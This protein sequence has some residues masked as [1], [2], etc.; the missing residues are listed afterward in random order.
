MLERTD[1]HF[2]FFFRLISHRARLYTE[3]VVDRAILHGDPERLLAHRAEERP[4][5]L[6]IASADPS[7]AARAAARAL[8]YGFDEVNLNVG[9]PSEKSQRMGIGA[10]LFR[11]P[12]RVAAIHRAVLAE[13]G[14]P[15]TVK[16]RIGL[17]EDEGYAPL[18]RFVE[19]VAAAGVRV[20]I[21]HARKALLTLSTRKNREVPPLRHDLVHRLKRDFPELTVVTNGGIAT[22]KEVR[23]HLQRVDGAMVG[24]AAYENP[25]R[26]AGVDRAVFALDRRPNRC[27]VAR[28]MAGYLEAELQKGTP[29]RTVIRPLIS[30][31]NGVP[32]ARAWRR[33][34]TEGPA[35]PEAVLDALALVEC[36]K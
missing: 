8:F 7:L 21:V 3:M 20:F 16:L 29:G 24:R 31:F 1:R 23:F 30:L 14:V 26:F 5:A 33:A 36:S 25:W 22:L 10:V 6:Q 9:C 19:R 32:G 13:T 18:F 15:I 4:L 17:D 2:R 28:A 34:L 12:E 35:T 11:E 27:R